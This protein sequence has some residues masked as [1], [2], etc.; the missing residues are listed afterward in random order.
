MFIIAAA[1]GGA[2]SNF[3]YRFFAFYVIEPHNTFLLILTYLYYIICTIPYFLLLIIETFIISLL[4]LLCKLLTFIFFP[5]D[6]LCSMLISF[7]FKTRDPVPPAHLILGLILIVINV[8][9][10][11]PSFLIGLPSFIV[12][13]AD[14][15]S[16]E[17]SSTFALAL[18][19][20]YRSANMKQI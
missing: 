18:E 17:L 3:W 9:L 13:M 8:I 15:Q 2:W 7:I 11:A 1:F 6:F 20:S 10:F 16:V 14:G 4:Y 12:V 19:N 5:F